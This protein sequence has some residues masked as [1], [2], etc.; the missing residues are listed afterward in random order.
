M[1]G[2]VFSA[3]G[4]RD[5][6]FTQELILQKIVIGSQNGGTKRFLGAESLDARQSFRVGTCT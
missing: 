3:L 5:N 6:V 4:S 1:A 2:R